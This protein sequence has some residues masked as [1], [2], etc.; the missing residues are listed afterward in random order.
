MPLYYVLGFTR[1]PVASVPQSRIR[2]PWPYFICLANQMWR[3]VRERDNN[4]VTRNSELAVMNHALRLDRRLWPY[5]TVML[6]GR[7]FCLVRLGFEL[8]VAP[9]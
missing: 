1:T 2:A 7:R 6:H 4:D 3:G 8:N 5:Q 9:C